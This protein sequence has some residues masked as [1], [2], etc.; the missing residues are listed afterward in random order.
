MSASNIDRD[1]AL[2]DVVAYK[3]AGAKHNVILSPGLL[4]RVVGNTNAFDQS[5]ATKW[6]VLRNACGLSRQLK[7]Q[8]LQLQPSISDTLNAE[9]F[10]GKGLE[11]ITAAAIHTLSLSLPD[12]ITFNSSMVDQLEWERV[13]GIE[14]TDGVDEAECDLFAIV[15]QFLCSAIISPITGPQFPESYQLLASDLA[16]LNQYYYSLALGLPRFFPLPG[17]PGASLARRRLLQSFTKLFDDLANPPIKRVIADD[18]SLSGEETDADAP[19]PF[20]ALHDLFT[21]HNLPLSA[22]A[23]IALEVIHNIVAQAVPLAFWTILHIYRASSQPADYANGETPLVRIREETKKWAEAIQPPSIHPSFPS[24][25]EISFLGTAPLFN[26]ST[27]TYLRSC[28]F[29]AKRI[30]GTPIAS[31]I[32]TKPIIFTENTGGGP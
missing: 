4:D 31:A 9:I 2:T 28:I 24:P 1:S 3:S 5:E 13:A 14:L 22:R 21:K 10:K 12:L 19:T 32:L 6:T 7:D 23:S 16:T 25:P 26:P 15:N 18:E 11:T 30:Y 27:F 17:L 29:E 20:T 8:Y